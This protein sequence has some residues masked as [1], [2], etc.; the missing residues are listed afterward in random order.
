MAE[1]ETLPKQ[2]FSPRN[3]KSNNW[4]SEAKMMRHVKDTLV[5]ARR[6]WVP[7]VN[8]FL[9]KGRKHYLHQW[10]NSMLQLSQVIIPS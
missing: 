7:G 10:R 9:L 8:N 5:V 3:A 1:K 4:L 6:L 2:D